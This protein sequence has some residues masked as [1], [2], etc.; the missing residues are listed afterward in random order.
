MGTLKELFPDVFD[1]YYSY[2]PMLDAL[3]Q[4]AVSLHK[5]G[6]LDNLNADLKTRED[7]CTLSDP[8]DRFAYFLHTHGKVNVAEASRFERIDPAH[9]PAALAKPTT[10]PE[11]LRAI[12]AQL[13]EHNCDAETRSG[14]WAAITE[15]L[16]L[17]NTTTLQ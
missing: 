6:L 15:V 13:T 3:T 11:L 1:L 8:V 16:P 5:S 4:S 7:Y 17:F 10:I 2:P 12:A 14:F 9:N